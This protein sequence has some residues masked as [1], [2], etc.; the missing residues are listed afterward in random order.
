MLWFYGKA[1][2]ELV[3]AT[4]GIENKQDNNLALANQPNPCPIE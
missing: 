2:L 1:M 4:P 3:K